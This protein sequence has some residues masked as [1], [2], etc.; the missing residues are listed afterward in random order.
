MASPD[1]PV[2]V[3]SSGIS[4]PL[5]VAATFEWTLA[6]AEILAV[7][8]DRA[9]DAADG[10]YVLTGQEPAPHGLHMTAGDPPQGVQLVHR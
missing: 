7:E 10:W 9:P 4:E 3:L 1:I 5:S 2:T 6:A 8:P